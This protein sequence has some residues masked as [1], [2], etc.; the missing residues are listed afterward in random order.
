[1]TSWP[2]TTARP[3]GCWGRLASRSTPKPGSGTTQ[4]WGTPGAP[5]Q[6]RGG[7]RRRA[8]S[9]SRPCRQRAGLRSPGAPCGRSSA[10]SPCCWTL[11]AGRSRATA[12]RGS[13]P[14]STPGRPCCGGCGATRSASARPTSPSQAT[15]SPATGRGATRMATTGSRA[16][17]TTSSSSAATTSAPQ[18]WSRHS[19]A[20]LRSRRRRSWACPTTLRAR[21]STRTSRSSWGS[22]PPTSSGPR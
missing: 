19:S 22:S 16:G 6:T 12:S 5:S 8:R 4:W 1:M 3:C 2:A 21:P 14:S 20:T 10:S 17:P 15:T 9:P 7:R 13:S 18:R 11:Q